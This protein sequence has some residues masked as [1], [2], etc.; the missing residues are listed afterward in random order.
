MMVSPPTG[1]CGWHISISCANRN[2]TW[3][4][5]RDAWYTLVPESDRRNGAMFFPPKDEYVNLHQHCFHV[6]E[7][8]I[9]LKEMFKD[10]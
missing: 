5:I 9:N 10:E 3:E 4:E 6:H 7:V 8:P 1:K 2:P